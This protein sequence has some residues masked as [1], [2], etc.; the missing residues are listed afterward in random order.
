MTRTCL[1]NP[2]RFS[3]K[4]AANAYNLL[5]MRDREVV[6]GIADKTP[7]Q[8]K[9]RETI[10]I[11]NQLP[12][13]LTIP[14][15]WQPYK[16]LDFLRAA[17]QPAAVFAATPVHNLTLS[18]GSVT[19]FTV[20]AGSTQT[21]AEKE[22]IA[23]EDRFDNLRKQKDNQARTANQVVDYNAVVVATHDAQAIE[24]QKKIIKAREEQ[25]R[26]Q[27]E[28]DSINE[29]VV[30]AHDT[31]ALIVKNNIAAAQILAAD[32]AKGE[33][34]TQDNID[35]T[36]GQT[37]ALAVAREAS[38]TQPQIDAKNRIEGLAKKV[39]NVNRTHDQQTAL[40]QAREVSRTDAQ[41]VTENGDAQAAQRQST[42]EKYAS[43]NRPLNGLNGKDGKDGVTTT[44][45]KVE[46]DT[47]TQNQVKVNTS[48]IAKQA[49][50]NDVQDGMI[51]VTNLRIDEDRA[52]ITATD[53]RIAGDE[54]QQA[55]RE[56][57]ASQ[58][59]EAIT[60]ANGADGK[61]GKDGKDGI[62]G[63]TTTITKV[64]NDTTTQ[65]QVAHNTGNIRAV[66]D[67]VNAQGDYIQRQ[68]QVVSRNSQR[69]D[70]NSAAI[71]QNS[72]RIDRNSKRIDDTRE[73]LKHGLD[74]AAA[75]S[76]LHFNGN[77]DSWALSTGTA[78][79]EGAAL[80]GG[81]QKSVTDHTAVTVQFSD[82]LNGDWMAGAGIHGDF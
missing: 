63:V 44:I 80:A 4:E 58:H 41:R 57:T 46:T 79:G 59:I 28:T 9:I 12:N 3:S 14:Q 50:K 29:A 48:D 81:L 61:D 39:D 82:A 74:N 26:A 72:N 20:G 13:T 18:D 27:A 64:E 73:D 30:E 52:N 7:Y 70:Q 1:L 53:A 60:S 2:W 62:D 22:S 31:Q 37:G 11:A 34:L 69:V 16:T 71:Q 42:A 24:A 38:R 56:R 17:H 33:A 43:A 21:D 76:S 66:G 49:R 10:V 5:N 51:E 77:H 15:G 19:K 75:M 35:R 32:A 23:R 65:K 47:E 54:I 36:A 55:N 6:A 25:A 45:T 8:N 40:M 67:V 78:N 68:S